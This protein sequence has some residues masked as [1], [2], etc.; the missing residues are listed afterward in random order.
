[1][2]LALYNLHNGIYFL[3]VKLDNRTI[4]RK[5]VKE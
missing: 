1:M 5:L 4:T 2:N 3:Q